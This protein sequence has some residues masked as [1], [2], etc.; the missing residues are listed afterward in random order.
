MKLDAVIIVGPQNEILQ[1]RGPFFSLVQLAHDCLAIGR[2]S[3][4]KPQYAGRSYANTDGEEVLFEQ[5]TP[6]TLHVLRQSSELPLL[7]RVSVWH[8]KTPDYRA[9]DEGAV[10]ATDAYA[11]VGQFLLVADEP[12]VV[13][14]EAYAGSQ[15]LMHGW[16]PLKNGKGC[17]STSVGDVLV[18]Q[19]PKQD[20]VAYQV[21]P[22]GF[23]S[24]TFTG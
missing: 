11:L 19:L 14:D 16:T 18:L 20:P 15:N 7:A 23:Q 17:R 22:V 2:G 8:K 3:A 6:Q 13:L 12:E 24:V 4:V 5:L 9:D 21:A 1:L 10:I